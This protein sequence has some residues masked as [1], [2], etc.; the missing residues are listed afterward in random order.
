V[1][2][3]RVGLLECGPVS[4]AA[5]SRRPAAPET[6]PIGEKP[7][8]S[9]A[10]A[11]AAGQAFFEG[12]P[13]T[14]VG[15]ASRG[16][17]NLSAKLA[18]IFRQFPEVAIGERGIKH[19]RSRLHFAELRMGDASYLVGCGQAAGRPLVPGVPVEIATGTC[20]F[21][22]ES[23]IGWA[24][25]FP[26]PMTAIPVVYKRDPPAVIDTVTVDRR[27]HVYEA[28][29]LARLASFISSFARLPGQGPVVVRAHV[30]GPEYELY[31]LSLHARG[32]LPRAR[33]DQYRRAVRHRAHL[34]GRLLKSSLRGV[35]AEVTVSSPLTGVIHR[36]DLDVTR[37]PPAGLAR[38][39]YDTAREQ[40]WL[41][42]ALLAGHDL[43]FEAII[44]ASYR[45]HY[46]ATAREAARRGRQLIF[47]E[48]PEEEKILRCALEEAGRTG[49]SLS[50]MPGFYVHPR[51]VV[52]RTALGYA[53]YGLRECA[54]GCEPGTVA[55]AV[56]YYARSA[57]RRDSYGGLRT[58]LS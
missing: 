17:R 4:A 57:G 19:E 9:L 10:S 38:L 13:V 56:G 12:T 20:L 48:N 50:E 11:L 37:V 22:A 8:R 24:G 52:T 7:L 54:D 30:P 45:Y 21:G 15:P 26:Y 49:I 6:A 16:M 51:V 1:L 42:R 46:L 41:W 55:A 2:V 5:P 3:D 44:N 39:A 18:M 27:A 14:A 33:F 58:G 29:T 53:S 32:L 36:L 47:A 43:S 28:E 23:V 35:A 40:G 34:I 31:G 25:S